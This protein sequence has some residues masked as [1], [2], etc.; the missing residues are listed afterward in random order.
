M[1]YKVVAD[2]AS[3][4][5]GGANCIDLNELKR[6]ENIE[7]LDFSNFTEKP[8]RGIHQ[9]GC[10]Y[11]TDMDTVFT[12]ENMVE[13]RILQ[14]EAR[15]GQTLDKEHAL[16]GTVD[17]EVTKVTQ[18]T[19]EIYGQKVKFNYHEEYAGYDYYG[20]SEAEI[21]AV[22][23]I[24]ADEIALDLAFEGTRY[25]DLMRIARH[26][27]NAGQDGSAWMAWLISRRA[28]GLAPYEQPNTTGS[29]FNYLS[30][31]NN[32]YLPAPKNR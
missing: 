20:P 9:A 17:P 26:R 21:A 28:L 24:I 11:F 10:G 23:T 22:E 5:Q 32:W 2:S 1:A 18:K 12:Y 19:M 16:V 13:Q 29:L 7:W 6:A 8:A 14:E 25:Y 30:D 4:N 3:N 15:S 31:P 27:N